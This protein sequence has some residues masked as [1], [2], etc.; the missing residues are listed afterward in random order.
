MDERKAD[1][2]PVPSHRSGYSDAS[3][4]S[5][6]VMLST[7]NEMLLDVEKQYNAGRLRA[8]ADHNEQVL[9]D[10]NAV[11]CGTC[12]LRCWE[13]CVLAHSCRRDRCDLR[14]RSCSNST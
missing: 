1:A 9:K 13:P 11:S 12:H 3:L 7:M 6:A 8:F 14:K 10:F 5:D 2:V 4:A